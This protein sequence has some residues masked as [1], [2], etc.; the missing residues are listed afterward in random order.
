VI[1]GTATQGNPAEFTNI[2]DGFE[3]VV[4]Q[5]N[6]VYGTT[7]K[8]FYGFEGATNHGSISGRDAQVELPHPWPNFNPMN[9]PD[10]AASDER[11]TALAVIHELIH[12][13]GKKGF[14]DLQLQS[15][16]R[17]MRGL[18]QPDHTGMTSKKA[19]ADASYSWS[20]E[21]SMA[22]APRKAR[23]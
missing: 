17:A 11:L 1:S 7:I 2:L 8:D 4:K 9:N 19:V 23:R 5:G 20:E 15:T 21:L 13:A 16:V 12:L 14:D 6:F 3:K 22:C 10:I 18:P